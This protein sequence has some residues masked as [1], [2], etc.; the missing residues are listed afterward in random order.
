MPVCLAFVCLCLDSITCAHT[1]DCGV[2]GMARALG[3]CRLGKV[4]EADC[5]GS[6]TTS[7]S[8][9]KLTKEEDSGALEPRGQRE[10]D[11]TDMEPRA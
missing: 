11:K 2:V 5:C 8:H 7:P 1:E 6:P 4:R 9:N 3:T 10:E